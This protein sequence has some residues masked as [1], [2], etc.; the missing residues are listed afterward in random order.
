MQEKRTA[1]LETIK[2]IRSLPTIPGIILKVLSS[3]ED[4]N[5][6]F[7][8]ISRLIATDQTLSARVLR[9]ANSPF[10][11]VQNNI[12]TISQAM[13]MLG[14][15]AVKGLVLSTI[16]FKMMEMDTMELWEHSLGA[17]TAALIIAK[18]L[19]V[20]K[21]EEISTAALLHDIGKVIIR[22]KLKDDY[23]DLL[24]QVE[25]KKISMTEAEMTLLGTDHAEIGE[26][27]GRTWNLPEELIEPIACHHDVGKSEAHQEKT[28]IVHLAD[29]LIKASGFGFSGD[30]FV[31]PI[32]DAAYKIL[33]LTEPLLVLLIE[34]IES[35]LLEVK[36]FSLTLKVR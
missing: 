10:Y 7:E 33:D 23:E 27:A 9:L 21:A 17:A 34:E 5:T 25:E 36:D 35:K 32:Q 30:P 29:I 12:S 18:R 11:S 1:F 14:S 26:W 28:A 6:S 8:E 2:D 19:K 20:A 3:I 13:L 16:V 24:L 15:N 4:E 22:T 31:P